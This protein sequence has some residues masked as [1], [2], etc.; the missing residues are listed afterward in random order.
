[1]RT[2]EATQRER[3]RILDQGL[4]PTWGNRPAADITRR[5]VVHLAENIAKRGG[6]IGVN[7]TL[8]LIRLIFNDGLRRG[9][10]TLEANPAHL[11]EPPTEEV[12]RDRHLTRKDIKAVWQATEDATPATRG[13]FRLA[14][15]TGQWIGEVG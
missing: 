3:T 2:R 14:L 4:V 5:E 10:Q 15:R 1:M 9:V 11:V 8:S 6:P 7:R 12:G 13:V